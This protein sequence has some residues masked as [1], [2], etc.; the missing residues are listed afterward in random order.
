MFSRS[1]GQWLVIVFDS[2]QALSFGGY[3]GDGWQEL[4]S[5]VDFD[6]CVGIAV[7]LIIQHACG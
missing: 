6:V 5:M 4:H 2:D 7:E 1:V 3:L